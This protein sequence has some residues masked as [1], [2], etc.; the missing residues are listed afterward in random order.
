MFNGLAEHSL[1]YEPRDILDPI[2]IITKAV[3]KFDRESTEGISARVNYV[4]NHHH[5]AERLSSLFFHISRLLE[6]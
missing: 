3:E 6:R 2:N 4:L 5:A 1:F